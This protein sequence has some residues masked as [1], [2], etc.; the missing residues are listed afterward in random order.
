MYATQVRFLIS[1]AKLRKL[2]N[3]LAIHPLCIFYSLYPPP[4]SLRSGGSVVEN[5]LDYQEGAI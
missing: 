1:V 5:M 4:F 2:F 3:V